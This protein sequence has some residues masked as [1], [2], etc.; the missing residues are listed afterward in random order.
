MGKRFA[1]IAF[2]PAVQAE[3]VRLGSRDHYAKVAEKGRDDSLLSAV[4]ASF[5]HARDSFYMAT[6]SETGWP[7]MQHRGGRPGFVQV[8]DPTTIG[9]ADLTGNRQHISVGNLASDDR[10]SLFFM[11]YA[12][13]RRLKLLGHARVVR[14]DPTLLARLTP[15]GAE[16]ITESAVVIELA[17]FDWNCPQHITPRYTAEEWEGISRA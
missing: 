2:T 1:E 9:F 11:D 14:D 16:R 10:V 7:Y 17:G 5:I 8:L 13:R 6:I 12:N 15:A 4:E 3:Q